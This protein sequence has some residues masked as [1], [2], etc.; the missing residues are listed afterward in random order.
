MVLFE[1]ALLKTF[2][3]LGFPGRDVL[4]ALMGRNGDLKL[5]LQEILPPLEQGDLAFDFSKLVASFPKGL[6]G[7][8]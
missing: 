8:Q 1:T 4:D 2:R 6:V 3:R 7:S 5:I